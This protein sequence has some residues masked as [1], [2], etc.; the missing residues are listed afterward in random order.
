MFTESERKTGILYPEKTA[1]VYV[2]EIF[3]FPLLS[4]KHPITIFTDHKPIL[5]LFAR[6]GITNPRFSRYHVLLTHFPKL[7]ILWTQGKNFLRHICYLKIFQTRLLQYKQNLHKTSPTSIEL[8]TASS[9]DLIDVHRTYYVNIDKQIET[10]DS[11][12]SYPI[13]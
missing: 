5:S 8:L 12:N 1:T 6:K 2:L 9:S 3:E 4:A 11:N 7:V 13:D 10:C